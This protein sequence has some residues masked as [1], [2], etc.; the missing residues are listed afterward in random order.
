MPSSGA[1]APCLAFWC[2]FSPWVL[3]ILLTTVWALNL[4]TLNTG[5]CVSGMHP[6]VSKNFPTLTTWEFLTPVDPH[7]DHKAVV[8]LEGLLAHQTVL[9]FPGYSWNL[10]GDLSNLPSLS[11]LGKVFPTKKGRYLLL[12]PFQCPLLHQYFIT[13]RTDFRWVEPL[14]EQE[15]PQRQ[16]PQTCVWLP[17]V[18]VPDQQPHPHW[19]TQQLDPPQCLRDDHVSTVR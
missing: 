19:T 13:S 7:M 14:Q 4:L 11:T 12:D 9:S 15:H 8:G 5:S 3:S 6:S 17:Q 1:S 16:D 18:Q 2:C 10:V